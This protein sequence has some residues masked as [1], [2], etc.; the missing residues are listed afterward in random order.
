MASAH[1][2]NEDQV[3]LGSLLTPSASEDERQ[4]TNG[5]V[6]SKRLLIGVLG[7]ALVLALV[8]AAS[9]VRSRRGV[10]YHDADS[11]GPPVVSYIGLPATGAVAPMLPVAVPSIPP[12][13]LQTVAPALP[14]AVAATAVPPLPAALAHCAPKPV[15]VNKIDR[16]E[17]TADGNKCRD[18]EEEFGGIC[19]RRCECLLGVPGAVRKS[20]F[21][22]CNPQMIDCEATL[23][24][25]FSEWLTPSIVPCEGYAV[26]S[27]D[28][29][30]ACPHMEGA[31][32]EDEEQNF[33]LCYEK[34]S[35]LT[36]GQYNY[37]V[38][39]ATCCAVPASNL[40]ACMPILGTASSTD[41]KYST[42]GGCH[43]L[44]GSATPCSPHYP[45]T[46]E[47]EAG[48]E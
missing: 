24:N 29:G 6:S 11:E 13:L 34:C 47:T 7:S 39:A 40:E 16:Q 45:S 46:K 3:E 21:S 1:I 15:P 8:G 37:R 12:P 9:A 35:I 26:S 32:L 4:G 25:P 43:D 42:G 27:A 38:A 30:T 23:E 31:C 28:G 20:E 5:V 41:P 22:C 2:V 48:M 19:F 17:N 18:S 36:A 33:Q 14:A 44:E 10:Q